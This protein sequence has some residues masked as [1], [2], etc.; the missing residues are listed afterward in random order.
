MRDPVRTISEPTI[1]GWPSATNLATSMRGPAGKGSV[2][3]VPRGIEAHEIEMVGADCVSARDDD[4]AL[5]VGCNLGAV[6]T[7][8][9]GDLAPPDHVARVVALFDEGHCVVVAG[10]EHR[11]IVRG[12]AKAT[13]VEAAR[14]VRHR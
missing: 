4:A 6:E 7:R 8:R 13:A 2:H 11:R 5:A 9:V 12:D 14:R 1:V 3:V 10:D